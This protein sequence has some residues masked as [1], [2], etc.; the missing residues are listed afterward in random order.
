MGETVLSSPHKPERDLR[1]SFSTSAAIPAM[2]VCAQ[3]SLWSAAAS[4]PSFAFVKIAQNCVLVKALSFHGCGERFRE[5]T[6]MENGLGGERKIN[7]EPATP[8]LV[9]NGE[10]GLKQNL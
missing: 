10:G 4:F 9:A 5:I 2:K 8:I 3:R 7:S 1:Q 6:V